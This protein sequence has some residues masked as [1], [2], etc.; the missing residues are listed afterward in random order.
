MKHAFLRMATPSFTLFGAIYVDLTH[1]KSG[2]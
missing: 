2:I 1:K